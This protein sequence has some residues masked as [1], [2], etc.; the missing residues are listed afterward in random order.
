MPLLWF[1]TINEKIVLEKGS[2]F[3]IQ[4][5][6]E[7]EIPEISAEFQM[8]FIL[9][10]SLFY[11][12]IPFVITSAFSFLTLIKLTRTTTRFDEPFESKK[13]IKFNRR[14]NTTGSSLRSNL[15]EMRNGNGNGS[16]NDDSNRLYKSQQKSNTSNFK[17]TIMVRIYFFSCAKKNILSLKLFLLYCMQ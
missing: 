11:C 16:G 4:I 3:G 17:I 8:I 10:D 7:C 2:T 12:L 6:K 9:I 1:A 15:T 5:T 14:S 13:S